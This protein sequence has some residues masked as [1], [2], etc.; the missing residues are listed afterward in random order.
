M[1]RNLFQQLDE[2][3]PQLSRWAGGRLDIELPAFMTSVVFHVVLLLMLAMVGYGANAVVNR[4]IS[5]SVV[6]TSLSTDL[7]R[8]AEFQDLDMSDKP[9][10]LTPQAG[11]FAPNLA[12]TIKAVAGS[13]AN[14]ESAEGGTAAPVIKDLA[15]NDV[16]RATDAI[17]P[18]AAMYG[19]MVSIKGNGA[20]HVGGVEG[21]VDRVANEILRRLE[22]GRVLAIWLFDASGSLVAERQRLAK[23][24]DTVYTH[25]T[26][27]DENNRS[28]DGGLLTGVVAFGHDLKAMT[29]EPTADKGAIIQAINDVPLDNTGIENTFG[30]VAAVVRKWGKFKDA[31]GN[32]YHPMVIIVTD[33]VGD[34]EARLEEAVETASKAKVPVYVLGSQALFGRADG[35]MDYTDP[36]TK[37]VFHNLPVRQ[38]PESAMIE[39]VRLGFWYQGGQFDMM[40]SGAGPWALSRLAVATGGTYF[41]TRMGASRMGF[42]PTLMH[43]YKPDWISRQQYEAGVLQ[44]PFRKAI[45]D[46]ALV[47]QQKLPGTPPLNFAP[48]DSPEFKEDMRKGQE[49]ANRT[50]YTVDEVLAFINPVAKLRDRETSRRWQA[51]FDLTRGRLLAMKVRC[52]EYN[53]LCAKM[54]RDPLKFEQKESNAWKLVPDNEVKSSEK[55]A[56]A[57]K[58]AK[59]LLERVL[60]EHPGTPW[61]LFAQRE[62]KDPFGFK[63]AETTVKPLVK[64]KEGDEEAKKK[65]MMAMPKP[66][67]PPKL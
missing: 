8:S 36:K 61:A 21:A 33:E 43:E 12:T 20:E 32:V 29:P 59:E 48:A 4:E 24:I 46:A 25:I 10:T 64:G 15:V 31:K 51:N 66:P 38:G 55:A 11:S 3:F 27:M 52:Y 5:S 44:N 7:S 41:I 62:L 54:K 45:V 35:Y 13:A 58:Q 50:E 67:E 53:W 60:K 65:K 14:I 9:P 40:D 26:Q 17:V 49:L 19:N 28:T 22:K 37:Q 57:A 16:K 42:D 56:A 6:D 34:D 63:W 30:T 47:S 2:R 39:Q 1:L 18:T 23:H